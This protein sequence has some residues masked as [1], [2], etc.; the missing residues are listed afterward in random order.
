MKMTRLVVRSDRVLPTFDSY[1]I[2]VSWASLLRRSSSEAFI[3]FF[4]AFSLFNYLYNFAIR[5]NLINLI[6]LTTFVALDPKSAFP[7]ASGIYPA[8]TLFHQQ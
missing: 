8:L 3:F 2:F 7:A 6:T 1:L 4:N 5:I